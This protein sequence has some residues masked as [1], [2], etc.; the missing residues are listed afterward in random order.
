MRT[1]HELILLPTFMERYNYLKLFGSVG[2]D[3]FGY[4]RYLNQSFYSSREWKNFRNHIIA[5]DLGNDMALDGYAIMGK[6]LIHHL[7]PLVVDDFLEHS[8]A[9]LDPDN[10]VCVSYD[11]HQAIHYGSE[12]KLP[13]GLIT[14]TPNDTCPWRC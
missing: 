2:D 3:K 13:H 6:V 12:E 11:T 9:L 14:R 4:D 8:N 10:V 7:N 1:Y 5:R